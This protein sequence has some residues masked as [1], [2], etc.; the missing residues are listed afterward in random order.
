MWNVKMSSHLAIFCHEV[1][2][3]YTFNWNIWCHRNW[4]KQFPGIYSSLC[5]SL[6]KSSCQCSRSHLKA[7]RMRWECWPFKWGAHGPANL[8][9]ITP[10]QSLLYRLDTVANQTALIYRSDQRRRLPRRSHRK[11]SWERCILLVFIFLG[12]KKSGGNHM[13]QV[14]SAWLAAVIWGFINRHQTQLLCCP[15]AISRCWGWNEF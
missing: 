1:C 2:T 3:R 6:L 13:C 11:Q 14:P 9:C 4:N 8:K 15:M 5:V 7:L 12:R 10:V